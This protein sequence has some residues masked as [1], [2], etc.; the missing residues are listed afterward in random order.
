M[1]AMRHEGKVTVVKVGKS[2]VYRPKK[3]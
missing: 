3:G 2:K 1:E